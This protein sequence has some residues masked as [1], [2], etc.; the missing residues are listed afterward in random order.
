[1][2]NSNYFWIF[3]N[4]FSTFIVQAINNIDNNIKKKG[5]DYDFKYNSN[6]RRPPY[7]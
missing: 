2:Q 7:P 5:K 3:C 6:H 4:L 1:M